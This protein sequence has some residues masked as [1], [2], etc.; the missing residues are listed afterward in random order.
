MQN[1][2]AHWDSEGIKVEDEGDERNKYDDK[3][4]DRDKNKKKNNDEDDDDSR[5][6]VG[7]IEMWVL[8]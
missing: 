4:K 1:G 2:E 6:E 3:D 7:H 8:A 5:G